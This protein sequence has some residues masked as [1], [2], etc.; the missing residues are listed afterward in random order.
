M[1]FKIQDIFAKRSSFKL[2]QIGDKEIFLNPATAGKVLTIQEKIG[3]I[4]ELLGKPSAENLSKLVVLL[5]AA[6]SR[7]LL[8][9]KDVEVFQLDGTVTHEQKGGYL[10]LMDLINGIDEQL[11]IYVAILIALGWDEKNAIKLADSYRDDI[12]KILK[13]TID[14]EVKKKENP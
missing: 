13:E 12:N 14:I 10:L 6:E 3:S 2:S 1:T 5:I 11:S 9:I 8:E 4:E 7:P